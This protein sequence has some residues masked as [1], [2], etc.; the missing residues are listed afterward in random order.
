MSYLKNIGL[1]AVMLGAIV[2][3]SCSNSQTSEATKSEKKTEKTAENK[4]KEGKVDFENA[5]I[6]DVRTPQEFASGH[7][8]GAINIPVNEVEGHL[9]DFKGHQQIV[10]YCQ[11]GA[12]SGKAKSILEAQGYSNV[13][14]GIN[15]SNLNK[16]KKEQK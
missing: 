11:S 4:Q 12:R 5:F 10:V 2:F 16:L 13:I 6:V 3:T 9:E 7:F 14:N 1:S 15:H 8:E